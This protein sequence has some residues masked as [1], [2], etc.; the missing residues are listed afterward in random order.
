MDLLGLIR[1]KDAYSGVCGKVS[2]PFTRVDA[3]GLAELQGQCVKRFPL[4]VRPA[5]Q[6]V[7]SRRRV[8][9]PA[10]PHPGNTGYCVRNS[11]PRGCARVVSLW[12]SFAFP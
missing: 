2:F 10:A 7:G 6:R 8:W 9:G 3:G 4:A 12:L 11:T 5:P 1:N